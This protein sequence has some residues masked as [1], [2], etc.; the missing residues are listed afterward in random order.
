MAL[1]I[2]VYDDSPQRRD[3]LQLLLESDPSFEFIGAFNDCSD[4]LFNTASN[5]PDVILMDIDMPH[6]NGIEG[7]RKIR[8]QFP[9]IKILMQTVF[10]D[11]DKIFEAICA[12]ANGYI[13]K[14]EG[15]DKLITA[16]EEVYKGGAPMTPTVASK[17]LGLVSRNSTPAIKNTFSLT[18][19]ETEILRFLVQGY[20]YKMIAAECNISYPT[21]NTHV[22]K[23]YSKLQVHSVAAAV[24]VALRKGLV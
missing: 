12:G 18:N 1:K 15:P 4:V 14:Q 9:D 20:S 11:N 8:T 22:T 6:V 3:S 5:V 10:E 24:S 13:L 23:I 17:V 16:I 19:R 7:V 21:V 2:A